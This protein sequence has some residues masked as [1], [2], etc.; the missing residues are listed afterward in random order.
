[1]GF[2]VFAEFGP[3]CLHGPIHSGADG[4]ARCET[5]RFFTGA[6]LRLS[7]HDAFEASYA[8][9]PN[10]FSYTPYFWLPLVSY[11][12]I[13][14]R[15][16]SLNY[17]RYLATYPHVQPFVTGGVGSEHF[18]GRIVYPSNT[19][20]TPGASQFAWNY[21]AGVDVIPKRYF[22]LRLELR[23]YLAT[24]PFYPAVMLH[25]IVPSV[26]IVFRFHRDRKL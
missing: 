10:N 22:A 7:R 1:M 14:L 19:F 16:Y 3:S 21:G 12:N 9:S 11:Q 6:R 2:D 18:Q 13:R 23:D 26:G 15:S 20:L 24:V 8:Y 4:N 25:N 5:G 17:V